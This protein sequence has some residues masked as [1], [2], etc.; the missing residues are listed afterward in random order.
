MVSEFTKQICRQLCAEKAI[1]A[2]IERLKK[3]Q[4]TMIANGGDL[5][6]EF[7]LEDAIQKCINECLMDIAE[8]K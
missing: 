3:K 7:L 5:S 4:E 2:E 6:E 1:D 8:G